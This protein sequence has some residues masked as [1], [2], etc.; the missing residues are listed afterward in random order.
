MTKYDLVNEDFQLEYVGSMDSM[1]R[2]L[3]RRKS[4]EKD[5][6]TR[7]QEEEEEG[8]SIEQILCRFCGRLGAIQGNNM[9]IVANVSPPLKVDPE[10]ELFVEIDE[11]IN[12][13]IHHRFMLNYGGIVVTVVIILIMLIVMYNV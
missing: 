11:L 12:K 7:G 13:L 5:L 4:A 1:E 3:R 6:L 9:R 10:E 2:D 8:T